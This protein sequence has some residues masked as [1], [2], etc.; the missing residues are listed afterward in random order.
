[1]LY[2]WGGKRT[3]GGDNAFPVNQGYGGPSGGRGGGKG[4]YVEI[5]T[6]NQGS[7]GG[8]GQEIPKRTIES[9]DVATILAQVAKD[10]VGTTIAKAVWNSPVARYIVPDIISVGGGF[11]AIVGAGTGSSMEFNWV[12]R[13]PEASILPI[14]TATTV[15]GGGVSLDFTANIGGYNYLGDVNDIRA[16]M[17]Y[18]DPEKN[19]VTI[20]LTHGPFQTFSIYLL[21]RT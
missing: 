5:K 11:T 3:V 15:V 1:M 10:G 13:G 4:N 19:K 7:N 2:F 8:Q 6:R 14:L 21:D 17:L 9:P 12:V 18:S 20:Y 16:D